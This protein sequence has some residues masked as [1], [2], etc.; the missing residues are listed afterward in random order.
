MHVAANGII[1]FFLRLG[2]IPLYMYTTPSLSA[3]LLMD[4]LVCSHV[5]TI[6]G[7]AAM[8]IGVHDVFE[9]RSSLDICPGVGLLGHMV[10]LFL[11]FLRTL[12]TI[13]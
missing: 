1:S 6:V 4:I 9:V 11:A 8:N 12:H 2:S 13:L 10:V 7:S 5:L 3:H